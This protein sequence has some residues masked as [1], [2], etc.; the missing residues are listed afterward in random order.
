MLFKILG[1]LGEPGGELTLAVTGE[2]GASAWT[3]DID[4]ESKNPYERSLVRE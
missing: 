1:S 2:Q 4:N 3:L